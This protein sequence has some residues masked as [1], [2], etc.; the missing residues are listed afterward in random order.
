MKYNLVN[1]S[2]LYINEGY[3]NH[4]AALLLLFEILTK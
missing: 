4:L 1:D 2:V 3:P